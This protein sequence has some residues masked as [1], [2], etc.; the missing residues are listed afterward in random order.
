MCCVCAQTQALLSCASSRGDATAAGCGGNFGG[1]VSRH[2]GGGGVSSLG[3]RGGVGDTQSLFEQMAH[4][5]M[6]TQVCVCVIS[7]LA[8]IYKS[9]HADA[10]CG[11]SR[12]EVART[13]TR[14]HTPLDN[15][16]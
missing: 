4:L 11:H 5:C 3:K 14:T 13:H 10:V 16:M 9:T 12:M 8:L 2:G 1:G 15:P 7:L 6:Q